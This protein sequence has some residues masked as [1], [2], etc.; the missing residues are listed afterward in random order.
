MYD[1]TGYYFWMK[2]I[3]AC[4]A[5]REASPNLHKIIN[6]VVIIGL[7]LFHTLNILLNIL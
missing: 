2:N 7:G 1:V 6:S 3:G 5:M 4:M